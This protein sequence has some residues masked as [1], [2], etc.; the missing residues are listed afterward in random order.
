MIKA[1]LISAAVGFSLPYLIDIAISG[2]PP[3]RIIPLPL[4]TGLRWPSSPAHNTIF[5]SQVVNRSQ[6]AD[7]LE[8]LHAGQRAIDPDRNTRQKLV[9]PELKIKIG[10]ERPFSGAVRI[11]E[12][13]GRCLADA[14]QLYGAIS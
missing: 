13:V 3:F 14:E 9:I 2:I 4:E 12:I 6:K 5:A 10:S 8:V 7:K 11:S 1:V